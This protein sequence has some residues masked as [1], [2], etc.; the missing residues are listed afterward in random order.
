MC[1]RKIKHVM[2][3]GS[4]QYL[5]YYLYE[6]SNYLVPITSVKKTYLVPT[7]ESIKI[8]AV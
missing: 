1:Q 7:S 3:T 5:T 6:Y 2:A 4:I 8:P